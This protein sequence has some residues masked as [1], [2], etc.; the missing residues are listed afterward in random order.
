MRSHF[1]QEL[2]M[3]RDGKILRGQFWTHNG[4]VTAQLGSRQKTTQIGGSPPKAIAKLMMHEMHEIAWASLRE[5]SLRW[6]RHA[7][8]LRPCV[9][10]TPRR[11]GDRQLCLLNG[12]DA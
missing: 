11:S 7:H 6:H 1:S 8:K 12:C 3:E 10:G 5:H 4:M 2:V 9:E